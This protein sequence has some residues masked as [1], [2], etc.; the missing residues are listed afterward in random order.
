MLM[1]LA[2]TRH[3]VHGRRG[4]KKTLS[5]INCFKGKAI[6]SIPLS[7]RLSNLP[8][9]NWLSALLPGVLTRANY[10]SLCR[11]AIKG[12]DLPSSSKPSQSNYCKSLGEQRSDDPI[13]CRIY[14]PIHTTDSW[15]NKL[16]HSSNKNSNLQQHTFSNS[17]RR[18]KWTRRRVGKF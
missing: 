5:M 13:C 11:E 15:Q 17:I 6:N 7:S 3:P 2:N 18:Q 8:A 12:E 1:F 14:K 16:Q 10:E 9:L 4:K